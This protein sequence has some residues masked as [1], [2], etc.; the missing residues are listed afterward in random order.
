MRKQDKS[1][2]FFTI[3]LQ[4]SKYNF[5]VSE[6]DN[7]ISLFEKQVRAHAGKPALTEP[8][9]RSVTFAELELNANSIGY[10]SHYAPMIICLIS[11]YYW[12][13]EF[14]ESSEFSE[15]S[16]FS[17]FISSR[18]LPRRGG[19]SPCIGMWRRRSS[20]ASSDLKCGS[21]SSCLSCP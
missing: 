13:S 7:M 17:K 4:S 8:D 16:E 9:G 14:S 18:L 5:T 11:E 2:H 3:I 10:V 19:R 21:A 15:F 1:T 6:D 20:G 12:F